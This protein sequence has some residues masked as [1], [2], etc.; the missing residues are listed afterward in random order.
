MVCHGRAMQWSFRPGD[1]YAALKYGPVT[2]VSPLI[3]GYPLVNLLLSRALL[4]KEDVGPQ[5]I[6]GVS[7]TVCG[8]AALNGSSS[9][10]ITAV[11]A[12]AVVPNAMLR[13]KL[14]TR[15][16]RRG[17][18]TCWSPRPSSVQ[19]VA[20]ACSVADDVAYSLPSRSRIRPAR[21][22]RCTAMPIWF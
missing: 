5:L 14:A 2:V 9:R 11:A 8:V 7:G 17:R 13:S 15:L 22:W 6:A 12:A 1:V 10:R 3:A 21:R 16:E 4:G 19:A 18:W 20:R